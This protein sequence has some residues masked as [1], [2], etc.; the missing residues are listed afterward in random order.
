MS[1]M[2]I[3]SNYEQTQLNQLRAITLGLQNF[4]ADVCS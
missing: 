1:F 2:S 3:L 4:L